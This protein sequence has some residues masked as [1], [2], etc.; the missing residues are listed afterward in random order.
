MRK[1]IY[2]YRH[3]FVGAW[4]HCEMCA[5][6]F[7]HKQKINLFSVNQQEPRQTGLFYGAMFEMISLADRNCLEEFLGA[8]APLL[9]PPKMDEF[10]I[11]LD[12]Y[13]NSRDT[14]PNDATSVPSGDVQKSSILWVTS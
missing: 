10:P 14:K 6:F 9:L 13:R 7:V 12:K 3:N 8:S 11:Y 4:S 1:G 2:S 5:L